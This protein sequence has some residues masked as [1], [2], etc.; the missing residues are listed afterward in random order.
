M[1][2]K[3][4]KITVLSITIGLLIS[5]CNENKDNPEVEAKQNSEKSV[6]PDY[7]KT[8]LPSILGY[9]FET[10]N[11]ISRVISHEAKSDSKSKYIAVVFETTQG[12]ISAINYHYEGE[13][14]QTELTQHHPFLVVCKKDNDC[15]D[16]GFQ[17]TDEG[18][19]CGCN[20]KTKESPCMLEI[21]HVTDYDFYGNYHEL[22]IGLID[23]YIT[24]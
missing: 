10:Y 14:N 13:Y 4:L 7:V 15:S 19:I 2:A 5:A 21:D 20:D 22:G 6:Q 16:C 9:I 8:T 18:T 24:K 17:V 11:G 23:E 3:L 1:L 12:D